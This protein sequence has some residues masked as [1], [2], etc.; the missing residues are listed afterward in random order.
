MDADLGLMTTDQLAARWSTT[1]GNLANLRSAGTG[2]R[3]VKIGT[4]VHYRVADVLAYERAS[5]VETAGYVVELH[6]A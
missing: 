5:T 1:R 3:Y 4:R 2:P 6:P